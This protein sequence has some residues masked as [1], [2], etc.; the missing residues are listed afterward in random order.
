MFKSTVSAALTLCLLAGGAAAQETELEEPIRLEADGKPIDTGK[1]VA[2]AGPL[3]RDHD[4]DGLPD[5]LVSA[6]RGTV[7]VFKNVGTRA[8]PQF[9]EQKP[10]Q[11]AGKDLTIKN[12]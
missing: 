3:V 12:W 1:D 7:R 6:F 8:A 11:A 5:L 2:Y 4:G 10:L 9:A